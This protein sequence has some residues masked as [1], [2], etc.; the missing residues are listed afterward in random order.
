MEEGGEVLINSLLNPIRSVQ[1]ATTKKKVVSILYT[2]LLG[3]IM[4]L[5]AKL[6]DAPGINPIF[7][8]I[9]GRLGIWI[10]VATL[11]SVF[12]YSPRV[13]AVKVFAF[14]GSMLTVY[15]IYTV[16]ILHFFPAREMLFWGI[17]MVISPLCAYLMWYARGHGLFSTIIASFSI[18]VILSEG[19]QLRYAYLPI[20]THYYLIPFLMGIYLIM[21]AVLLLLIPK[22]KKKGI[23]IL[24]L[25]IIL[26]SIFIYFNVLGR[27][28][29]GMN[30]FL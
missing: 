28:F 2:I 7:D 20:H 19:Y 30:G 24:T 4:G 11:L 14:F 25:T 6:V 23:L 29:G 10:F 8:D 3:V 17:C 27:I 21:I 12:S 5:A 9:G 1:P 18:T 16:W 13:A 26:S 15:Y 22:D